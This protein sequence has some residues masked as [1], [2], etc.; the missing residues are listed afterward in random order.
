[1]TPEEEA[2]DEALRRI[3]V[4]KRTG[5]LGLNLSGLK[6]GKKT[7]LETLNRLPKD[8]KHLTS[9]QLLNL[10]YC[11]R[12]SGDLSPLASLTSLETLDLFYCKQLTTSNSRE[13]SA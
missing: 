7:E 1:M 11:N 2:N 13:R 5:A 8:L 4:A 10:S 9:L 6:D 3:R 12:L